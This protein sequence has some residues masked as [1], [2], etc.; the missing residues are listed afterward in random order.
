MTGD[1]VCERA[2]D[3]RNAPLRVTIG[4]HGRT[5]RT[6]LA[7]AVRARFR[8]CASVIDDHSPPDDA[9]LTIRVIGAAPRRCDV[10]ALARAGVSVVVAGKAD[11]RDDPAALAADAA[12]ELGVSVYPVSG[13]LAAVNVGPTDLVRLREHPD[14]PD[15]LR[16][17]GVAGV[18]HAARF[19]ADTPERL[20]AELRR[21][22]G[23]DALA[24]AVR[25]ASA[26]VAAARDRRL[27]AEL[28]LAAA[29]GHDRDRV[30]AVLAGATS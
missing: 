29:R 6:T 24:A 11:L 1:D 7:A 8:L 4:G 21:I 18:A 3:R 12:R 15:L 28:A 22:S 9:D 16:R 19:D 2:T 25:A 30:E 27:R 10:D 23:I 17:F 13:L 14:D 5:G 26:D 20:A